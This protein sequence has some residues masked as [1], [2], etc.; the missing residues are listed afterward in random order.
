MPFSDY[1]FLGA[2]EYILGATHISLI[3]NKSYQQNLDGENKKR[4]NINY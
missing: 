2:D 4:D 1:L 3:H